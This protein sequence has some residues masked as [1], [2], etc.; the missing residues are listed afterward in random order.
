MCPAFSTASADAHAPEPWRAALRPPTDSRRLLAPRSAWAMLALASGDARFAARVAD[1]LDAPE[2]SR[3]RARLRADGL[4]AVLPLLYARAGRAWCAT[5]SAA[6]LAR[7]FDDPRVLS[8]SHPSQLQG[9]VRAAELAALVDEYALHAAPNLLGQSVLLR[10]V[11]IPGHLRTPRRRRQRW[12]R[13]STCSR[14]LSKEVP[15]THRR[16]RRSG[17]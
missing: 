14:R 8:T 3:A 2:A 6:D 9:Y 7:L 16:P 4:I 12:S 11:A 17:A 10:P 13:P 5:S 15:L 1:G